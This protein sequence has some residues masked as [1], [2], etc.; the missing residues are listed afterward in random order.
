M[1]QINYQDFTAQKTELKALNI[2]NTNKNP[3]KQ[4]NKEITQPVYY[5]HLQN[6]QAYKTSNNTPQKNLLPSTQS[7]NQTI[8]L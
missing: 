7:L 4:R 3:S 8:P 6:L 1:F 5:K 2:P